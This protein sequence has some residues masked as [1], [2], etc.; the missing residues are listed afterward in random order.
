[1]ARRCLQRTLRHSYSD[2]VKQ[3]SLKHEI[4]WVIKNTDLDDTIK[5]VLHTL[6]DAG[7]FGAHSS[8][9]GLSEVYE[10]SQE[11]LEACF[12]LLDN[13]FDILYV[14]PGKEK[15]NPKS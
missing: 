14:Q 5:G 15:K 9:D 11:D 3:P 1:M 6:R 12:L 2:M 10:L 8:E 13:L 7:N 4:D